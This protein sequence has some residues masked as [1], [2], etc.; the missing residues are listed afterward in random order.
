MSASQVCC[1]PHILLLI[2]GEDELC[3]PST[4]ASTTFPFSAGAAGNRFRDAKPVATVIP[5]HVFLEVHCELSVGVCGAG[6]AR[7][8]I[9]PAARTELL[10]HVFGGEETGMAAHNE[11]LEVT[12]SLQRS[13]RKQI[14]VH[15]QEN[16]LA[17]EGFISSVSL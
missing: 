4:L 7:E 14:Q 11:G 1:A 9:F 6:N 3:S 17:L 12:D 13:S 8:G 16:V 10:V 15:L 2:L 5:L